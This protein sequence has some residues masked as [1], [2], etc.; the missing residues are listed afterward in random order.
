[1]LMLTQ[2]INPNETTSASQRAQIFRFLRAGETI[3][4]QQ[5]VDMFK[6]ARLSARIGEIRNE[7]KAAGGKE[8]VV[9]TMIKT[10]NGKKTIARYSL[11]TVQP[12]TDTP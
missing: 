7:L 5:A 1:M 4:W 11:V 6:C 9:T 12:E 3:T 10:Q 2:N 8:K